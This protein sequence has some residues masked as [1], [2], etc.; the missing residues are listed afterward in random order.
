MPNALIE[1]VVDGIPALATTCPTGPKEILADGQLGGLVPPGDSSALANAIID[2]MDHYTEWKD[3]AL[4]ARDR[5]HEMFDPTKG[6]QRLQELM[7]QLGRGQTVPP[8]AP[9]PVE[10]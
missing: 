8:I 2:A 4:V 3:R 1:A 9:G 10:H 7:E 6:M 5:V